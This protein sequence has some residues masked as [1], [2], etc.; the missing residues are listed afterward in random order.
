ML[1]YQAFQT[2]SVDETNDI[3]K[4]RDAITI[5][6]RTIVRDLTS[7]PLNSELRTKHAEIFAIFGALVPLHDAFIADGNAPGQPEWSEF[8]SKTQ[9]ILLELGAKLDQA[10]YGI[11]PDEK[12]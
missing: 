4:A 10:G 1:E 8:W 9:L 3:A 5:L 11:K 2:A 7:I 6:I 12:Q